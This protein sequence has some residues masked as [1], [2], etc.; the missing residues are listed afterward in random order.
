MFFVHL[1]ILKLITDDILLKFIGIDYIDLPSLFKDK[2]VTSSIPS[3]FQNS[4]PPI[5]CFKYNKPIIN[6]LL[7]FNKLSI[8]SS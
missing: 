2:S 8:S 7:N 1:S 4:E 6:T 3:Y 5:I